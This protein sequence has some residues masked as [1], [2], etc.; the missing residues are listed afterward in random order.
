MILRILRP[1]AGE[2]LIFFTAVIYPVVKVQPPKRSQLSAGQWARVERT[3]Q[4]TPARI[5]DTRR[6]LEDQP[7]NRRTVAWWDPV[8]SSRG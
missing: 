1:I 5:P 6:R 7:A 2:S 4:W 8:G 3:G